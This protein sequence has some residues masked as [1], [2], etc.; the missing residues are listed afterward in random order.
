V[1][2]ADRVRKFWKAKVRKLEQQLAREREAHDA[3]KHSKL[4]EVNYDPNVPKNY[5]YMLD[6]DSL[7]RKNE[8]PLVHNL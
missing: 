7:R 4:V 2:K 6:T 3:T 5:I 1:T 8:A